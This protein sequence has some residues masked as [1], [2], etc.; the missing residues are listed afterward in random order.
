[1]R[2]TLS[3]PNVCFLTSQDLA[4]SYTYTWDRRSVDRKYLRG[5]RGDEM[6]WS[7]LR[8]ALLGEPRSKILAMRSRRW[9]DLPTGRRSLWDL[10]AS[11]RIRFDLVSDLWLARVVLC[12]VGTARGWYSRPCGTLNTP[13]PGVVEYHAG[14]CKTIGGSPG[15][16]CPVY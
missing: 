13:S 2:F 12:S 4:S 16:S 14:R 1:M 9:D 8:L 3:Y 10:W 7:F 15:L 6:R 11:T 5:D